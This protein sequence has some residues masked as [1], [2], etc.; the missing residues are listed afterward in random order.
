MVNG[1]GCAPLR[2]ADVQPTR[3]SS[4]WD[5]SPAG[6]SS[7]LSP[8]HAAF[9]IPPASSLRTP[10]RSKERLKGSD[11]DEAQ[12]REF[13]RATALAQALCCAQTPSIPPK[14]HLPGHG[15]TTGNST[16]P[17]QLPE[18]CCE[19]L[20]RTSS[21]KTK[22]KRKQARITGQKQPGTVRKI[23]GR[24]GCS[25]PDS[26]RIPRGK[27]RPEQE[28]RGGSTI[29]PHNTTQSAEL[30]DSFEG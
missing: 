19:R 2:R 3:V 29:K 20:R 10:A 8:A 30:Q 7:L 22:A 27:G 9:P 18:T 11:P 14:P 1:N 28:T 6:A 15:S 26:R 5:L 25:P 24:A 21:P 12:I 13:L 4:L 23:K 16:C 17:Q